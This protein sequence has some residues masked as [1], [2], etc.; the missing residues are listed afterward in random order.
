[1][2]TSVSPDL[3]WIWRGTRV[4][5]AILALIFLAGLAL[6]LS[7][8]EQSV[9][10]LEPGSY[11][12]GGSHA[13]AKLLKDQGVDV[14]TARTVD[15]ASQAMDGVDGATLLV[16]GP[17]LVPAGRLA[18][19]RDRA[20]HLVLVEP[21]PEI[22]REAVPSVRFDGTAAVSVRDP[23]CTIG[24]AVAAGRVSLGGSKY[25]TSAEGARQC[26]LDG[27]AGTLV[28]VSDAARTITVLGGS[29]PLTNNALADE[30]NAALALRLLGQHQRLVWY[31]PSTDDPALAADKRPFSELIPDGWKYGAVQV[32]VAVL[33][34]AL[35]RAR[36][37][38]PVVAEPLPIVVRA[39][40][41]AEGRARL[42]RKAGASAH[43]AETLREASRARLRTLLGL[44]RD[45]EAA[46]LVESISTRTGRAGAEIGGV[47][48]G[49]P[50]ADDAAL[51]RLAEELD[52]VER[53][54]GRS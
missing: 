11:E 10:A 35:W 51:V 29:R 13:L 33:L 12:P 50:P 17:D 26:Y 20:A 6:V 28:Q 27:G 2:T 32:G 22:L 38:G 9:G 30:G 52:L 48:Y 47:L 3:R 21:K 45:T 18:V 5:L 34:L 42:Y 31:L 36:R 23:G 43:A 53:E 40:E 7:R 54:V 49:P 37:L 46:A 4:P 41:T 16:T 39:A 19:L 24:A 1:M 15:E 8:G 14:R 25:R 44:S